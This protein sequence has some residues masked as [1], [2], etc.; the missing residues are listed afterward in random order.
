M[1][2]CQGLAGEPVF[3]SADGW[4]QHWA[5]RFSNFLANLVHGG[6]HQL[7]MHALAP[8]ATL[9]A[10]LPMLVVLIKNVFDETA[11]MYSLGALQMATAGNAG[12]IAFLMHA[13]AAEPLVILSQHIMP[14]VRTAALSVCCVICAA[15]SYS[16]RSQDSLST[17]L[18]SAGLLPALMSPE[19]AGPILL[20]GHGPKRTV[21]A[22]AEEA[23]QMACGAMANLMAGSRW[24]LQAVLDVE[25]TTATT[26]LGRFLPILVRLLD[27][28]RPRLTGRWRPSS[29]TEALRALANA[30]Y[31]SKAQLEYLA[32]EEEDI[33]PALW[34]HIVRTC[35]AAMPPTAEQTIAALPAV[36]PA[37]D[38]L[39]R[40][41]Q[42]G[43]FGAGRPPDKAK[44][45]VQRAVMRSPTGEVGVRG[46][47][48]FVTLSVLRDPEVLRDP[49]AAACHAEAAGFLADLGLEEVLADAG[50][51]ESTSP[52][53]L[54]LAE[55]K[56][57]DAVEGPTV[58]RG[59]WSAGCSRRPRRA[60]TSRP[61]P[62][63]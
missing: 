5:R 25:H 15:N 38:G 7:G 40:L 6:E 8:G 63:L 16:F 34:W 52:G 1:L 32:A 30:T 46:L 55:Q 56:A 31:G 62:S 45:K 17:K 39:R 61:W 11:L 60:A 58:M 21:D 33:V 18:V 28:I 51:M 44:A 48:S 24:Q 14:H 9:E 41:L 26:P 47:A 59:R 20:D 27:Q 22:V 49:A 54:F 2:K 42:L 23:A 19:A 3:G 29:G 13:D 50:L 53:Q 4:S 43:E 37:V 35:A 36:R 12:R 57:R 10:V